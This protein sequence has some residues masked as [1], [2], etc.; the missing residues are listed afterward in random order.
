MALSDKPTIQERGSPRRRG[1]GEKS[2][3]KHWSDSQKVECVTLWLA[4]G[5]LRLVAATMGIPEITVRVWRASQWW[6]E[7]ADE[8]AVQDRIQMS[9]SAKNIIN[10]SLE[11]VHDRLQHGDWIYDQKAGK[12]VRK[13]VA[14]KDALTAA[15]SMIDQK[16]KLDKVDNSDQS[17]ESIDQRLEKLM[18]KFAALAAPATVVTDVIYVSEEDTSAKN[19]EGAEWSE[20][21]GLLIRQTVREETGTGE[22]PSG[23]QFSE[24]DNE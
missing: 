9:A 5:N 16:L 4:M 7:L 11:V 8:I 24:E 20:H 14:M 22:E 1:V 6:K 15:N 21:S 13:P 19:E 17:S 18:N 3:G 12:L 2:S 10:K 23:S